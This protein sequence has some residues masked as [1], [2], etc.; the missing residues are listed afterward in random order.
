MELTFGMNLNSS[1]ENGENTKIVWKNEIEKK[2]KEENQLPEETLL[3][4]QFN[5]QKK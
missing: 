4:V 5:I 1:E 3:E 2:W